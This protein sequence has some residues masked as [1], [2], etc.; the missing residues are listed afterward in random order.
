MVLHRQNGQDIPQLPRC[1]REMLKPTEIGLDLGLKKNTDF[2]YFGRGEKSGYIG[3]F[4]TKAI[5]ADSYAAA[6]ST[7]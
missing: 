3:I 5:P 1:L 4:R 2:V 7:R 6:C